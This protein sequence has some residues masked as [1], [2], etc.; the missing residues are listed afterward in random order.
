MEPEDVLLVLK[1]LHQAAT[2]YGEPHFSVNW[3][4]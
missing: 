2:R 3:R 1:A 4:A